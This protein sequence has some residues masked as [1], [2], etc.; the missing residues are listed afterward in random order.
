MVAGAAAK[1]AVG[2]HDLIDAWMRLQGALE[3][4]RGMAG[5]DKAAHTFNDKYAPAVQAVWKAFRQAV[6]VL[7]GTS[8]GLTQTA[9]NHLKADHHS[10]ADGRQGSPGLLGPN[11]V[12]PDVSM[13]AP[14]DAIGPAATGPYFGAN[15]ILAVVLAGYWPAAHPNDLES[16][17]G[18][19]RNA[20]SEVIKVA[21]W[22]NWAIGQLT[23]STKTRDF[24]AI[25]KYWTTVYRPGDGHSLLGGLA[26]LC[27]ALGDA[28]D[29]F[30]SATWSAQNKINLIVSAQEVLI[31]LTAGAENVIARVTAALDRIAR[32]SVTAVARVTGRTITAE[33]VAELEAATAGTPKVEPIE[34]NFNATVGKALEDEMAAADGVKSE[35]NL[36]ITA[37]NPSDSEVKAAEYLAAQ[38]HEVILRDP[39]GTRA[40]GM[41][42]DLLVD[43]ER[44]DVYTPK[45]SN[46]NRIVSAVASKGS[47]VHGGGVILDLS[48]TSVTPEDLGNIQARIAGTGGRVSKIVVMPK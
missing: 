38:G 40:G 39:V 26:K 33:V 10:R 28:C 31:L 41:T 21:D 19:W 18:A 12:Y 43:G 13:A 6:V 8:L 11:E 15:K 29:G 30:A 5:D 37:A 17:A 7:G 16:A 46:P 35:G 45:S 2:Q 3:A 1:F 23:D 20:A 48:Q 24:A 9:N 25:Q 4:N 32:A 36:S 14:A 42:S 47:Q 22:L 34:A 44:W 27:N